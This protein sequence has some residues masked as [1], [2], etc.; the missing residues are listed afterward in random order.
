MFYVYLIKISN[1]DYYKIGFTKKNPSKRLKE[2]QTGSPFKLE[3]ISSFKS[4]G[5][6]VLENILHKKFQ[7]KS[8]TLTHGVKGEW[9]HFEDGYDDFLNDCKRLDEYSKMILED[10]IIDKKAKRKN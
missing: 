10:R 4:S 2:L 8:Q 6:R 3:L 9:F 7:D 5:A 1:Q